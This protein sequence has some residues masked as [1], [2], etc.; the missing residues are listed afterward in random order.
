MK[1][2]THVLYS[3]VVINRRVEE[4]ARQINEDYRG[5]EVHLVI[6]LNGAMSFAVHLYENLKIP[7]TLD[8]IRLSSYGAGTESSG[9][10]ESVIGLKAPI[11]GRHVIVI[12]DIV[13]TGHT[14]QYLKALLEKD[15]PASLKICTLLN[16]PSRREIAEIKPDYCGFDIPDK[17]V[18]GYGLDYNEKYRNLPYI[19]ELIFEE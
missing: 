4:L 13:D 10:V 9:R 11:E 6:V 12:E 3:E 8:T 2:K 19:G 7:A 15:H 18:I 14:M 1:E 5:K 17:F 16:K